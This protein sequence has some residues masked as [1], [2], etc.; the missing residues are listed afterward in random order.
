MAIRVRE[1]VD[2][3]MYER[4]YLPEIARGLAVTL[5]HLFVNLFGSRDKR[6][7]QTINYPDEKRVYP[8]RYRGQHRL[9]PREDGTRASRRVFVDGL[10]L[11]LAR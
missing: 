8:P 11:V 7:L 3:S 1:R 9:L 4:S 6:Y 10:W 2:Y 5:R